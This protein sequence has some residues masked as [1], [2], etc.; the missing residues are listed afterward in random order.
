MA[1]YTVLY[2][3]RGDYGRGFDLEE[4]IYA[5]IDAAIV[6]ARLDHN[7]IDRAEY[8]RLLATADGLICFRVPVDRQALDAAPRLKVAVR[9]G[10]GYEN[11]DLKA[12]A[13]RGIPACNVPDYGSE[14]VALH[15]LSSLLALRR[16][17][18]FFDQMLRQGKW[19]GWPGALPIHRLSQ[20]TAG[21]IGLGRIGQAFAS[22]AKALFGTVLACD[23]YVDAKVFASAGVERVTLDELLARSDAVTLH[24]PLTRETHHLIGARELALMKPSAVL[25]NTSRGLVLDQ[26]ALARALRTGKLEGAAC[27]VWEHEPADLQHPL[28]TCA[29]FIASP[30]IAGNSVEGEADNRIKQAR[31]VVRVLSGQAPR[32]QVFE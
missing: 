21:I 4:P 7:A 29:N 19:R 11:F 27:D 10:V 31:E 32:N 18:V 5:E 15:A 12:F 17:V 3:D 22:R 1:K 26:L 13:E 9:A 14:E 20:Q 2:T 30:H 25:A 16:R 6:D 24:V 8:A 23:P 28:L